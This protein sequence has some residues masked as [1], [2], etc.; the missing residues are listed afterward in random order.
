MEEAATITSLLFIFF[1]GL[2]SVSAM[3]G[4]VQDR[5]RQADE[6]RWAQEKAEI[7]AIADAVASK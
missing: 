3:G 6:H 7:L 5:Q 1:V 4:V 2:C